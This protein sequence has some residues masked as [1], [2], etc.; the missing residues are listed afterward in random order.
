M[1]RA[2]KLQQALVE[3]DAD[4]DI[5]L[6]RKHHTIKR[7]LITNTGTVKHDEE[8]VKLVIARSERDSAEIYVGAGAVYGAGDG[9]FGI[10]D[11]PIISFEKL[12]PLIVGQLPFVFAEHEKQRKAMAR[13]LT[14]KKL[15]A[16]KSAWK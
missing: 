10:F 15:S 11:S 1:Q 5:K 12:V 16:W 3:F 14:G 8:T 2:L 9:W 6:A 7:E 4:L 13:M